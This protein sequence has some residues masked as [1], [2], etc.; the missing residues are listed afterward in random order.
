[1]RNITLAFAAMGLLAGC[2]PLA[3]EGGGERIAPDTV[4][5]VD[6]RMPSV[7]LGEVATGQPNLVFSAMPAALETVDA[8]PR[9]HVPR[10]SAGAKLAYVYTYGGGVKT[11]LQYI[12]NGAAADQIGQQIQ[13]TR[14]IAKL[15]SKQGSFEQMMIGREAAAFARG[16]AVEWVKRVDVVV[17][18]TEAPVY[19]VLTSYNSILWNIQAAPGVEI[20]GIV[21][22]AY[23]GGAI[24]NGVDERRTA[25]MGFDGSPNRQCYLKGRA[26]PATVETRIAG[27]KNLNPDFDERRY[28]Q[29]WEAEYRQGLKFFRTDLPRKFG[30]PPSWHLTNARGGPFQAVLVG[31]KPDVAF[32]QAPISRLQIPSYIAPFWGTR[33]AAFEYFGLS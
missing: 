18:E 27:A 31:P 7:K 10:P 14:E 6:E 30:R 16:N 5:V 2:D 3:T 29:R 11:P 20:D 13:R 24:A 17:T 32:E 15:V 21:V 33:R 4:M 22:S 23:E 12:A 28:R 26:R 25:F 9:C 8:N 1:M 19:L